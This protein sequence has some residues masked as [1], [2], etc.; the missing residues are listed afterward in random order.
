METAYRCR[1]SSCTLVTNLIL[2]LLLGS[3]ICSCSSDKKEAAPT[4][5]GSGADDG[6]EVDDNGSSPDDD[7]VEIDPGAVGLFLSLALDSRDE[8]WPTVH[9]T[10]SWDE[11]DI[12]V[13]RY[14]PENA[15]LDILHNTTSSSFSS[16]HIYPLTLGDR[17]F[18]VGTRS[19]KRIQQY[20]VRSGLTVGSPC[21]INTSD[22]YSGFAIIGERVFYLDDNGDLVVA[23]FPCDDD[24][25][26]LVVAGT[27]GINPNYLFGIGTELISVDTR[28]PGEFR[29]RT[30]ES[31][32]GLSEV[33]LSVGDEDES[34]VD[35]FAGDDA[36]YWAA[37]DSNTNY[38]T[39]SRYAVGGAPE[40]VLSRRLD[41]G[42]NAGMAVDA[43][44]SLILI[45]YMDGFPATGGIAHFVLYNIVDGSLTELDVGS[46]FYSQRVLGTQVFV[47]D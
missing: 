41:V 25:M 30:H 39:V 13:L 35:F 40:I 11:T 18:I 33:V 5:P 27:H 43:S 6:T 12:G 26:R 10:I 24:P 23:N 1:F 34:I 2:A 19:R 21:E 15:T 42:L 9:G 29:V 47:F 46:S 31:S 32:T 14:V 36:L 16:N 28:T 20:D 22:N 45:V 38:L 17:L 7:V 37:F 8:F 4:S 44:R 3:F